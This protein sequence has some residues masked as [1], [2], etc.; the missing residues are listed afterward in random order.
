VFG[1]S[2]GGQPGSSS[3][4]RIRG[5]SSLNSATTIAADRPGWRG[6]ALHRPTTTSDGTSTPI[7]HIQSPGLINPD[8]IESI[9]VL[10]DAAAAAI[11]GSR[12][13][14]GVLIIT[15]KKGRGGKPVL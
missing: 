15:T 1:D 10:K 7:R 11:Y 8:D 12:A 2:N 13:S 14:A 6:I 3:T 9:T 5:I 4:I